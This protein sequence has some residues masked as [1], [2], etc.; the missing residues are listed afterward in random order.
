MD[1]EDQRKDED[2][3]IYIDELKCDDP[4]LKLNAVSKIIDISKILGKASVTRPE[5]YERGADPL[6]D[7]NNRGVRQRRRLPDKAGR[8]PG[9]SER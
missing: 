8:E 9:A 1:T 2:I 5:P 7:R 6:S 4:N 3:A